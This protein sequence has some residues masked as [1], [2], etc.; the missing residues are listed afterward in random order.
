[1]SKVVEP[2][3]RLIGDK[4]L[5][6]NNQKMYVYGLS[7]E[8]GWLVIGADGRLE[9]E[10]SE[11][12]EGIDVWIPGESEFPKKRCLVFFPDIIIWDGENPDSSQ[13]L[14]YVY[15][16]VDPK[17]QKVLDEITE[18]ILALNGVVIKTF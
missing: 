6:G 15:E 8:N 17:S 16:Y 7:V 18:N 12:P 10:G 5:I 9:G 2:L 1:M 11:K 4:V 3:S 13:L 14:P